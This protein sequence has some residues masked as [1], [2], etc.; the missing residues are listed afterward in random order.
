MIR[1]QNG[2]PQA[3]WYSQHTYGEA[4]S[5]ETVSKLGKRPLCYSAKGSHAN[6]AV[7]GSHDL[8]KNSILS[9]HSTKTCMCSPNIDEEVPA[10]LAFDKT[11]QGALWDPTLSAY[12]YTFSTASSQFHPVTKT[13]PVNYLYFKG[14]WGD[15]GLSEDA[16]G[17]DTFHGVHK[18]E[19]GPTGPLAKH[20]DRPD[21]CMPRKE[22]C[23]IQTA[24]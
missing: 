11:S 18:W 2:L 15:K 23:V 8:H 19:S 20:L 9:H 13:T 5:Y 17:Q 14:A 16:E 10:N 21:V 12:Y 6:Y 22:G 4:F 1:F 24:L 7:P 3:I